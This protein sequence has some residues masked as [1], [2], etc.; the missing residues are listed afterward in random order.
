MLSCRN[1]ASASVAAG[2]NLSMGVQTA[3]AGCGTNPQNAQLTMEYTM[4]Q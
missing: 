1:A 4:N 3:G 2:H